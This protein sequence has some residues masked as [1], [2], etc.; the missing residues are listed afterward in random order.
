MKKHKVIFQPSGQSGEINDGATLLEAARLFGVG[1][2]SICGGKG[3]CGKCKVRVEEGSFAKDGI[4]SRISHL[5]ALT[6][7][8]KKFISHTDPGTRLACL[9][10]VHGDVRLFVPEASRAAKQV[11][12]KGAREVSVDVQP[13][14][15]KYFLQLAPP[16]LQDMGEGDQERVKKALQEQYGLSRLSVDYSALKGIQDTLRKGE[17]NV[18][19][20]LWR[21][22]EIVKLEPGFVDSAYGLAVDVG[23]TTVAGYLCDLNTGKVVATESAINPQVACGEDVMSRITYAMSNPDGLTIMQTAIRECINRIIERL[24]EA[25]GGGQSIVDMTVVFNTVMHHIFL[26]INPANIGVAPFIPAM[27]RPLDVKARELGININPSSYIHV[28]PVVAGFVG[29]DNVGVLIAE[30]PYNID[31]KVLI[32]DIG[33][34]GELLLGNKDG[35]SSASC[36]TGPAF[37]GAQIKSGMRAAEG[38]IE[39]V[40]IDPA[41]KEPSYEVIGGG[42]CSVKAKGICGSGVIDA[43]A[44]LFKAGIIDKTGRFRMDLNTGR[45]RKDAA[46]KPEYVL[47]WKDETALETDI[48]VTQA[49]VRAVQLAKGALYAG[50]KLLMRKMGMEKVDKVILAG[51]FGSY[52]NKESALTLGMFPDCALENIYAVGN[53]AGDGAVMALINTGKREEAEREARKLKYMEIAMEPDFQEEFLAAMDIP[54]LKDQFRTDLTNPESVV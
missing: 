13:A 54:H 28:L 18:T 40:K 29:P 4:E 45:V 43:V 38:A 34:N 50:A 27:E 47:A 21:Q 7:A 26:G 39:R 20:T 53:A 42:Y 48:T 5:S 17:W 49:D 24:T 10:R 52:I 15:K 1:I 44:E 31:E 36:A 25:I 23:T 46:G 35:V 3:I 32:I 2:E 22:K 19:V 14:V 9:C 30:E 41:T 11:A 6:D 33:T 37:E 16:S 12:R 51:A 8:E